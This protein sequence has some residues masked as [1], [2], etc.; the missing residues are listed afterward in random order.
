MILF[1]LAIAAGSAPAEVPQHPTIIVTGQRIRDAEAALRDCLA[2]HC[3]P[4][5]DIDATLALAE[6]QI[7]DG[8]Y[9]DARTTLLHSLGRNKDEAKR[10]PVP[11]SDLYRANA[12]VAANLGFDRDYYSSTWGIYRSLKA[13]IPQEDWRHYTA[14]FEIAEMNARTRGHT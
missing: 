4:D 14:L 5:K 10:Y 1:A 3:A 11:V 9:R 8:D 6:A 13:G 7:L 12:K 2:R